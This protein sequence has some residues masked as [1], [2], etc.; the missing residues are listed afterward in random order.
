LNELLKDDVNSEVKLNVIN[1]IIKVSKVIGADF[2]QQ[3]IL[4][5]LIEMTKDNNWRV[6]MDTF[7]LLANLGVTFGSELFV[8]HL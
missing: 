3:P 1:G 7:E 5:T 8:K 2:L 4:A 6:R